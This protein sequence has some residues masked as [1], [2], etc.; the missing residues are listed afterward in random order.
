M[1]SN[2]KKGQMGVEGVVLLVVVLA[3]ILILGFVAVIGSSALNYVFDEVVPELSGLGDVG[4]VNMSVASEYT[5]TPANALVPNL[6]WITGVIYV[7]MLLGSIGLAYSIRSNPSGWLIALYFFLVL[8]LIALS[9]FISNM[10]QDI[11]TG[12]DTFN[13]IVQE[14][15]L[16]SYMMLYSPVINA[17]IA[18]ISGFIMFSGRKEEGYI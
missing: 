18:F 3:I 11:Y 17:I 8:L 14:H 6:T 13:G 1:I 12:T 10:Y 4:G 5:L 16:M 7:I 9:I 2:N 15:S